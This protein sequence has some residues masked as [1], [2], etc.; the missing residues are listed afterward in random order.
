MDGQGEG[1]GG[2]GVGWVGDSNFADG[3]ISVEQIKSQ[4]AIFKFIDFN[5]S[6]VYLHLACLET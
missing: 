6:I 5:F 2:W 4:D 1:G 3:Q